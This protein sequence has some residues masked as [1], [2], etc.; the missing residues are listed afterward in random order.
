MKGGENEKEQGRRGRKKQE[1]R[2]SSHLGESSEEGLGHFAFHLL[3]QFSCLE[4]GP[5]TRTMLG[6][7]WL[8][9]QLLD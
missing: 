7:S 6:M 5:G 1:G 9:Y 4:L 8:Y 3:N 2:K